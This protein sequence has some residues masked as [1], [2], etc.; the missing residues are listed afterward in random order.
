MD[1][2]EEHRAISEVVDRL[3]KQFPG[4]PTE[5]VREAVQQV[6]PEFEQAPIRD[7]VPLFVERGAKSRLRQ[8]TS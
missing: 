5:D 8:T 3:A 1:R 7:F 6:Q 2:S 4:L